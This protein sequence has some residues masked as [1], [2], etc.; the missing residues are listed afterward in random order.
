MACCGD[1]ASAQP[2]SP[3]IQVHIDDG[4]AKD[5]TKAS[6]L[7]AVVGLLKEVLSQQRE[8]VAIQQAHLRLAH[9]AT[10]TPES[11]PQSAAKDLALAGKKS[12][13]D[14]GNVATIPIVAEF[15][16]TQKSQDQAVFKSFAEQTLEGAA[17]RRKFSRARPCVA[18]SFQRRCL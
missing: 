12:E 2:S 1:S 7:E 3:T 8:L 15:A 4:E 14:A 16:D 17:W 11:N 6:S 9:A 18:M 5:R 13:E 10:A